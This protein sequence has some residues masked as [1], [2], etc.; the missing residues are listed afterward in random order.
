[1]SKMSQD[2]IMCTHIIGKNLFEFNRTRHRHEI[3]SIFCA[4][5]KF[6]NSRMEEEA[7][8]AE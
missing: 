3:E 2:D 7:F 8:M 6:V 1:M 4:R 5:D